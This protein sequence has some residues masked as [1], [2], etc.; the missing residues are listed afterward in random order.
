[1]Y[2]CFAG[3]ASVPNQ[4]RARISQGITPAI[5]IEYISK[6]I[7][8]NRKLSIINI[9]ICCLLLIICF[10]VNDLLY[11]FRLIK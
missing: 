11:Y 3:A 8:C 6:V 5:P 1:M 10:N 7:D 2:P 4:P 9:L